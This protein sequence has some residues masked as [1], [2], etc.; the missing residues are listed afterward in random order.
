MNSVNGYTSEPLGIV[1]HLVIL[2]IIIF[3]YMICTGAI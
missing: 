2:M 3:L 1:A